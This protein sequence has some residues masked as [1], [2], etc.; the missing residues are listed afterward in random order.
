MYSFTEIH[1]D[2][3]NRNSGIFRTNRM[4]AK[5]HSI[6]LYTLSQELLSSTYVAQH[7]RVLEEMHYIIYYTTYWY[8]YDVAISTLMVLHDLLNGK[9][10]VI[11]T[12]M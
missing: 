2:A 5:T 10:H 7:A 1:Y 8:Y 4:I 6:N 9:W 11:Y 12:T 3:S